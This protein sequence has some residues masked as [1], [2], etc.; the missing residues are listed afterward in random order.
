M[1]ALGK[2]RAHLLWPDERDPGHSLA[3]LG[4]GTQGCLSCHDGSIA[5]A[6]DTTSAMGLM[7]SGEHPVNVPY[8]R[9]RGITRTGSGLTPIANL[10]PLIRLSGGS[11]GCEAC[12]SPYSSRKDLLVMPNERS[13]LCQSCHLI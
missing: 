7:R 1:H 2:R 3:E 4:E 11:V 5:S 13:Q 12:H 9:S 10:D 8:P 6:A